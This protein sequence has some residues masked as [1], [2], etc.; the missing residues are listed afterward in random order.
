MR[1][2]VKWGLLVFVVVGCVGY[3]IYSA[4]GGSAE[5]YQTVAELRRHPTSSDVRVLGTVENDVRRTDGGLGVR[6]SAEQGG[7]TLPVAY[8]GTLPDIFRPGIQVVV[9]G[10]M[11][12][13][14]FQAGSLLAKCPSKF[15][16]MPG[17]TRRP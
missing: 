14:V 5:Y 1:A 4:M 7:A 2:G 10:R 6:F 9:E 12:N 17:P 3:L 11:S 15:T 8:R 13:G 16:S